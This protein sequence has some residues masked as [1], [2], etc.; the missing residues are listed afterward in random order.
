MTKRIIT[1]TVGGLLAAGLLITLFKAPNR[2]THSFIDELA[3]AHN[4]SLGPEASFAF[5]AEAGTVTHYRIDSDSKE[6]RAFERKVTVAYNGSAF[7]HDQIDPKGWS[8]QVDLLVDE[9]I[10]RTEITQ[11]KRTKTA[12]QLGGEDYQSALFCIMS[13]GPIPTLKHLQNLAAEVIGRE[14]VAEDQERLKVKTASGIWS[15]YVD[16]RHLICKVEWISN[17]HNVAIEYL[18]YRTV[19]GAQLPFTERISAD[20]R[21]VHELFFTRIDLNPSFPA[22]HFSREALARV[23]A[24]LSGGNK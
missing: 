12:A 13:F 15:V 8:H 5:V 21:L 16:Q 1:L 11:G 23:G 14:R 24:P 9:K 17:G 18:D 6:P 4:I 20:G 7:I 2:A 3:R 22:D 19:L 10:Y